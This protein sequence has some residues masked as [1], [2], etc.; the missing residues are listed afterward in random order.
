MPVKLAG[1]SGGDR[2]AVDPRTIAQ[3]DSKEPA[4]YCRATIQSR[5]AVHSPVMPLPQFK[6]E[7]S[8]SP[9]KQNCPS[10]AGIIRGYFRRSG[11]AVMSSVS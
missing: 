1:F 10:S 11:A 3:V 6:W 4:R 2:T 7:S 8:P 9:V 5:W